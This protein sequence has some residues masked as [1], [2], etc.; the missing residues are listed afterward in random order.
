MIEKRALGFLN[1]NLSIFIN[2]FKFRRVAALSS[3]R[4]K[5]QIVFESKKTKG[6][7]QFTYVREGG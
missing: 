5:N 6:S 4:L 1:V 3:V 2:V 7:K